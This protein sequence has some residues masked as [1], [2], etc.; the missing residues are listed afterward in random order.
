M[1]VRHLW[2]IAAKKIAEHRQD[3]VQR[4]LILRKHGADP[5]DCTTAYA[6]DQIM[7]LRLLQHLNN[8]R[9][10]AGDSPASNRLV[11]SWRYRSDREDSTLLM[12]PITALHARLQVL[13]QNTKNL[14]TA[15]DLRQLVERL[16]ARLAQ[17]PPLFRITFVIVLVFVIV[18][19]VVT[20]E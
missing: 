20:S 4:R 7:L 9:K 6:Y 5:A 19:V 12:P 3:A 18:V 17:R 11:T 13:H 14:S 15:Y 2:V 8:V 10:Y 1:Y 16:G